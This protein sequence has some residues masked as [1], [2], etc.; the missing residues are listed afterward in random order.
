MQHEQYG[1]M[2]MEAIRETLETMA[3]AEIV[4]FSMKIGDKELM[5]LEELRVATVCNAA[6]SQTSPSDSGW[7]DS[8]GDISRADAWGET[9]DAQTPEHESL[10][11]WGA[12]ASPTTNQPKGDQPITDRMW[13]NPLD[14]WEE[15]VPL[16]IPQVTQAGQTGQVDFDKLVGEQ[17]DWCWACL[18]V[19]SPELECIW[20]IVS[21]QLAQEL[22]RTMYAGDEFQLDSP[23]L[24]DII[25]ELTNVLG[26]RLMLLLEEVVGKFTLEVPVT[27]T[28]YPDLPDHA[29]FETVTCK[30]F[31]DGA[32]PVV[33]VMCFKDKNISTEAIS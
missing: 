15:N 3:F 30:V 29:K 20:F 22:A 12:C 26:G 27:G 2:L 8:S 17:E 9:P 32:Y 6:A 23:A 19:N 14:T 28:E 1:R 25:A 16:P 21:K 7:S 5:N 18:K 24:R 31:V 10:D 11:A 4:P 33:S 13:A